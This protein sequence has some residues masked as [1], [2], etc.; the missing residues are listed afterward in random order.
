MFVCICEQSFYLLHHTPNLYT[1]SGSVVCDLSSTLS[2]HLHKISNVRLHKAAEPATSLFVVVPVF[3]SPFVYWGLSFVFFIS[4]NILHRSQVHKFQNYS[5]SILSFF[6]V[7]K[8][9]SKLS[10]FLALAFLLLSVSPCA[11]VG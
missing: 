5:M 10:I 11:I 4:S 1:W 9:V 7:V 2:T 8:V 6:F 3:G